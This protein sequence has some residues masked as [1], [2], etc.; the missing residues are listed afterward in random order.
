LGRQAVKGQFF[1]IDSVCQDF[2]REFLKQIA[3]SDA[4]AYH[5]VVQV[6]A[7]F[8]LGAY[9]AGGLKETSFAPACH[10]TAESWLII[11]ATPFQFLG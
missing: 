11:H 1:N 3:A 6:G 2:S 9:P 10:T 8:H 5:I 4:A 7:A